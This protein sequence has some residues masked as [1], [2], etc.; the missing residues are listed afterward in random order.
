[1]LPALLA[2]FAQFLDPNQGPEPTGDW[3]EEPEKFMALVL[4]GFAIGILGH[5]FK[6]KTMVATGILMIFLATVGLPVWL[7]LTR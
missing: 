2:Q 7:Q 6:V 3:S 1:V 4:I 5:I